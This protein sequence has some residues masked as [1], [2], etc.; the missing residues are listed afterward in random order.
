MELLN[1]I[2]KYNNS[3]EDDIIEVYI[4][5]NYKDRCDSDIIYKRICIT[6]YQKDIV[7]NIRTIINNQQKTDNI[8]FTEENG[9]R[10]IIKEEYR[11]QRNEIAYKNQE[12]REK[13]EELEEQIKELGGGI[14]DDGIYYPHTPIPEEWSVKVKVMY[15]VIKC[16]PSSS[17]YKEIDKY[18][19]IQ[20]VL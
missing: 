12:L 17:L 4:Q 15:F 7:D 9:T 19:S 5:E 13:I 2:T 18:Y 6:V 10:K 20:K 3:E 8:S 11:K 14:I 16:F 1:L